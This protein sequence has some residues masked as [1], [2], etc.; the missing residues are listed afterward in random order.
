MAVDTQT[1]DDAQAEMAEHGCL[2]LRLFRFVGSA[3]SNLL[4]SP[5]PGAE[6]L[7]RASGGGWIRSV[8]E[9]D[10]LGWFVRVGDRRLGVVLS[11][12]RGCYVVSEGA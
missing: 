6:V 12:G 4:T 1:T 10:D 9:H 2:A 8:V 3:G 5:D 7:V 11:A